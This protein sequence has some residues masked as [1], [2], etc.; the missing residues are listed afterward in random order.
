MTGLPSDRICETEV[1]ILNKLRNLKF[2]LLKIGI[3]SSFWLF[4]E[5]NEN[6]CGTLR[7]LGRVDGG[8]IK[9]NKILTAQSRFH[10]WGY[11]Q[12][13]DISEIAKN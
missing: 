8:D 9:L 5:L 6:A 7:I 3:N 12:H 13:L 1:S 4:P 2:S 11:L 10:I